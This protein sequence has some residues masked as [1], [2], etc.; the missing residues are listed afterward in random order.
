MIPSVVSTDAFY[1]VRN[2]SQP[3]FAVPGKEMNLNITALDLFN[4]SVSTTI[5]I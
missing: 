2:T 1:L 5:L 4:Q 3:I